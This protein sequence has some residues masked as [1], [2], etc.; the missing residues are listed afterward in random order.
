M[1]AFRSFDRNGDGFIDKQ[2]LKDTLEAVEGFSVTDDL[3]NNMLAVADVDKD[4][5]ISPH[6]FSHWMFSDDQLVTHIRHCDDGLTVRRYMDGRLR[7][8]FVDGCIV[9]AFNGGL[10]RQVERNG[11]MVVS[12]GEADGS[13]TTVKPDGITITRR[14]DGS[15]VQSSPDSTTITTT[16]DGSFTQ[17][18]ADGTRVVMAAN[19]NCTTSY[20]P[21]GATME[22]FTGERQLASGVATVQRS[23]DGLLLITYADGTKLQFDPETGIGIERLA[24]GIRLQRTKKGSAVRVEK[25][26]SRKYLTAAEVEDLIKSGGSKLPLEAGVP[27]T[28]LTSAVATE[29]NAAREAA[30]L[31]AVAASQ[32]DG[33]LIPHD[34]AQDGEDP[35]PVVTEEVLASGTQRVSHA[36]GQVVE[37]K[38]DGV[39]VRVFPSGIKEQ[40]GPDGIVMKR[41]PDDRPREQV[42]PD[43]TSTIIFSD[44]A[45][46]THFPDGKVIEMTANGT[47]LMTAPDGSQLK[48]FP[49]GRLVQRDAAGIF[50]ESL[51][52]GSNRQCNL[53]GSGLTVF[54]DGAYKGH[55][56]GYFEGSIEGLVVV[57]PEPDEEEG[58]DDAISSPEEAEGAGSPANRPRG[59]EQ[60]G[61]PGALGAD[62]AAAAAAG[63]GAEVSGQPPE[64]PAREAP[65]EGAKA[66]L[67]EPGEAKA[68]PIGEPASDSAPTATPSAE[69]EADRSA[70]NAAA[71]APPAEPEAP[72]REPLKDAETGAAQAKAVPTV[73]P[74]AD[75]A[76][77]PSPLSGTDAGADN[78]VPPAEPEAKAVPG[79]EPGADM[80]PAVEPSAEPEARD[81]DNAAP[82]PPAEP[83]ATTATETEP[84]GDQSGAG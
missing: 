42:N 7:A 28:V 30:R 23:S 16:S 73:E 75:M 54:V 12:S 58:V 66:P 22:A 79:G 63:E 70:D 44:G 31:Q 2:E 10:R 50:I 71:P 35:G 53:D 49:D 55:A 56:P 33:P 40:V 67:L 45:K 68:V 32:P 19:S 46:K 34:E 78:A 82:A 65:E 15:R 29:E 9:D 84:A 4:S 76:P 14:S 64:V 61:A 80:T 72:P 81:A 62:S 3:V 74:A 48:T 77:A 83:E 1:A 21:N 47:K 43:G 51:A 27:P 36:N 52:D 69:P 6:E 5:R 13:T 37:R 38:R 60:G 59:V 24:D 8:I 26:G 25:D 11:T 39:V 20:L 18:H 41:Y 17:V 57:G